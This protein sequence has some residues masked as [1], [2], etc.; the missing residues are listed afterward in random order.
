VFNPHE[1]VNIRKA[2]TARYFFHKARMSKGGNYKTAKHNQTRMIYPNSSMFEDLPRWVL[3][4]ELV[5]TT[6]EYMRNVVEI[7][8]KWLLEVAPH[9]YKAKELEDSTSK[10]MP[11]KQ[12][13]SRAELEGSAA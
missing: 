5:F 4:Y 12:G 8:N 10:L 7:R 6:M 13:K 1:T 2:V 11:K 3:Y 9:Y